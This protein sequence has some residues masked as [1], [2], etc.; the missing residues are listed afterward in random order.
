MQDEV[1]T[2]QANVASI[3]DEMIWAQKV[4]KDLESWVTKLEAEQHAIE[5]LR[6]LKEKHYAALEM[7]EKEVAE[8]KKE[9][10]PH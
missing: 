8:L 5:E 2:Q 10:G 4:S 1:M 7:H 3:L 9:G 6:K